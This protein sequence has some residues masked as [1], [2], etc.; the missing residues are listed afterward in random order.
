VPPLESKVRLILV[1][2]QFQSSSLGNLITDNL[3]VGLEELGDDG[4]SLVSLHQPHATTNINIL[5]L[6]IL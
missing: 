4:A 6:T 3:A 2:S 5:A 1:R